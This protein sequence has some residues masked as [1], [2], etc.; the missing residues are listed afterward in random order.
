MPDST[1]VVGSQCRC[2]AC[3]VRAYCTLVLIAA[4]P[5]K[6]SRTFYTSN[7]S[8]FVLVESYQKKI[9]FSRLRLP[10]RV[11]KEEFSLP[12]ASVVAER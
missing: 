12:I 10:M 5:P 7:Y 6:A 3:A 9:R 4:S 11:R 8:Y 2:D 1:Y